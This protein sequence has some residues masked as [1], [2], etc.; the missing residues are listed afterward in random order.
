MKIISRKT[1]IPLIRLRRFA[2]GAF[3]EDLY[4]GR[5][6]SFKRLFIKANNFVIAAFANYEIN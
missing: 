3:Q 5:S 2:N 6:E 1:N 4:A